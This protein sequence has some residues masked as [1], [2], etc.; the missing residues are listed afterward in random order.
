M[1]FED[2]NCHTWCL[3]NAHHNAGTATTE[4]WAPQGSTCVS[5]QRRLNVPESLGSGAKPA[6]LGQHVSAKMAISWGWPGGVVVKFTHSA[7]VAQGSQVQILGLEL[8]T[9][10]QAML[11]WHPACKSGGRLE[12]M[13]AKG[14]SSSP[15]KKS[16]RNLGNY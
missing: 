6:S 16:H 11:W 8:Y 7:W 1:N 5:G 4:A 15:K 2:R 10:H 9:A 13:L 12:Q 3:M 14:Q